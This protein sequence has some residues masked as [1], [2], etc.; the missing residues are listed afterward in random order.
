M[1]YITVLPKN[2]FLSKIHER[3]KFEAFSALNYT[4]QT[5]LYNY[6][7]T[8]NED[9]KSER[10]C[11][12]LILLHSRSPSPLVSIFQAITDTPYRLLRQCRPG[13]AR[14]WIKSTYKINYS[15]SKKILKQFRYRSE[16]AHVRVTYATR[17][18]NYLSLV[19]L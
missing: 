13:F 17:Q 3:F 14:N 18:I 5:K 9:R 11:K 1:I 7:H 4:N 2:I 10:P 19:D 15:T 16:N 6:F 8:V 12:V